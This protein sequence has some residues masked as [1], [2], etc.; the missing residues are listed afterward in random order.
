MSSFHIERTFMEIISRKEA[1]SRGLTRY[2]TGV[3]C[4]N[5]HVAERLVKKY[6]C[7][8]CIKEQKARAR[9]EQTT[10]FLAGVIRRSAKSRVKLRARNK[11]I[12]FNLTNDWVR[13]KLEKGVCEATGLPFVLPDGTGKPG[14]SCFSP[15]L[16]RI[17]PNKG[18][19][20]DNTRLV[21][22]SFNA[23]KNDGT[24]EDVL[25]MARALVE[26]HGM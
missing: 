1:I 16:D 20:E 5:G 15:S 10:E 4:K 11:N 24:D 8:D 26:I 17:N 7:V 2:F 18:Y 19:T 22:H 3:K 6:A 14:P 12:E 13:A 9:K 25:K 21:I 23:A